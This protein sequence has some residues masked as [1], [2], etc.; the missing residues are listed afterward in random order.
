MDSLVFKLKILKLSDDSSSMDS[1]VFK[2]KILKLSLK[3]MLGL[4]SA[5]NL[6]VQC[7]N[8]LLCLNEPSRKLLL[9]AFKFIN[10]AKC[11]SF[12]LGSP[13]LNLSM[14]LGQCLKS[15]RFLFR[16]FFNSFLQVLKLS[17]QILELG[18]KGSTIT[19]LRV[20]KPLS[21]FQLGGE[22]NFVLA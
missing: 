6:L 15:I 2:L 10:A 1:L 14:R 12:K 11:L 19:S 9:A 16:L 5:S 20:S 18:K 8:G 22:R 21:I 4:F 7:F 13:Q 17:V 3:T